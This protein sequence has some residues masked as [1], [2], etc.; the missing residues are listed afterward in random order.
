MENNKTYKPYNKKTTTTKAEYKPKRG[1]LSKSMSE[2]EKA[3]AGI[4]E[5]SYDFGC[6]I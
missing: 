5:L 1:P 3:T 6:R 2:D 4:H